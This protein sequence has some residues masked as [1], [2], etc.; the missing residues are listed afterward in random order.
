[1]LVP[2]ISVKILEL[3]LRDENLN[4]FL[5]VVH[6]LQLLLTILRKNNAFNSVKKEKPFFM[7]FIAGRFESRLIFEF[8]GQLFPPPKYDCTNTYKVGEEKKLFQSIMI[9]A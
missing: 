2:M 4:L 1:L 3:Y 6:F 7:I 5:L 8:I 9:S